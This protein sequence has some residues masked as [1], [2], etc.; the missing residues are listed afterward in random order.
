MSF[1]VADV[2]SWYDPNASISPYLMTSLC[3]LVSGSA[4]SWLRIPKC[5]YLSNELSLTSYGCKQE[6]TLSQQA[7]K[8]Y[9]CTVKPA[10]NVF[11]QY[12]ANLLLDY[13][14]YM[15]DE[16]WQVFDDGLLF[17]IEMMI[18]SPCL[19][20][21]GYD[22]GDEEDSKR[23]AVLSNTCVNIGI[24]GSPRWSDLTTNNDNIPTIHDL[25]AVPGGKSICENKWKENSCLLMS[26][27]D[28][29]YNK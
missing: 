6:H 28:M 9:S 3:T 23:L 2:E 21:C 12:V 22:L 5:L 19:I 4:W 27:S 10:I 15:D 25:P 8:H 13:A 16:S 18:F 26:D 20:H 11:T 17:W 7:S 14:L 29:G 24:F 1:C